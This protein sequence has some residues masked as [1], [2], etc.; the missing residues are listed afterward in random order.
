MNLNGRVWIGNLLLFGIGGLIVNEIVNPFFQEVISKIPLMVQYILC[1]II[2][3]GM[4]TDYVFSNFIMKFIKAGIEKSEADNT[5]DIARE[6][7]LLIRNK[8]ILYSRMIEAYPEISYRTDKIQNRLNE[9]KKKTEKFKQEI[10]QK[11]DEVEERF[12][13]F[14]ENLQNKYMPIDAVAQVKPGNLFD[15]IKWRGDISLE[16]S[17]F[18]EIDNL[19]LSQISYINFGN[20]IKGNSIKTAKSIEAVAKE[21]FEKVDLKEYLNRI[22][23]IKNAVFILREI[24]KTVRFK[25]MKVFSYVKDIDEEN[26]FQFAVIT[27]DLGNNTVYTSFSGTDD[28][29][30]G[31]HED[32]NMV[33]L[34]KTMGQMK[35][36][37]YI[38]KL[39]EQMNL[40]IESMDMEERKEFVE[41]IFSTLELAGI[42]TVDD[43]ASEKLVNVFLVLVKQ[44]NIREEYKKR[45]AEM[46]KLLIKSG[47]EE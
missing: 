7:R 41:D 3:V 37:H 29:I 30:V 6:I 18:N 8:N 21:F 12:S 17:P 32:F 26:E 28:T 13:E 23:P 9:I 4:S 39:E 11:K 2:I 14:A 34:K 44:K 19:I 20:I 15:Y 35:A 27:I 47:R 16:A 46:F 42:K 25:D 24:A 10:E 40:W 45:I 43:F 22:S 38:V 5:E 31:W 1:G 33:Y 36:Q